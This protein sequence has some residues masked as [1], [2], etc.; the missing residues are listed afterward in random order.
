MLLWTRLPHRQ[1]A[2]PF[3]PFPI[4]PT[5]R[6]KREFV[7]GRRTI[8]WEW[9]FFVFTTRKSKLFSASIGN[10][11]LKSLKFLFL[12]Y[13]WYQS[14]F[15]YVTTKIRR[16]HLSIL[17]KTLS[18]GFLSCF[19][20]LEKIELIFDQYHRFYWNV[21]KNKSKHKLNSLEYKSWF[22]LF[23]KKVAFT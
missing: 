1:L 5:L 11:D 15:L 22:K 16:K 21:S 8:I 18:R 6:W 4:P 2:S 20:P 17:L 9:R 3:H 10:R 12:W 7:A 13:Q 14:F 19:F 23:I